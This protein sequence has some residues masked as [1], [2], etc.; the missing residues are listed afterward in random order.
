MQTYSFLNVQA[1][2]S[3]PGG[4][5][6]MGSGAGS[7][8]EGIT[9]SM[10]EEKTTMTIGADGEGMHSLHG[11]NAGKATVRLLKTSPVNAQLS[12]LYNAQK[13]SSALWGQNVITVSDPTRGDFITLRG[14][15]FGKHPDLA[16]AKD[17]AAIEWE[18][19]AI[20][21]YMQAGAGVPDVN[22]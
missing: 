12:A 20:S 14:A 3:G 4:A 16:F 17:G 19:M 21:V 8:E 7:A 22:V 2:I 13:Q 1:A 6:S 10:N 9:V 5:F 11:G 18:F 15:A